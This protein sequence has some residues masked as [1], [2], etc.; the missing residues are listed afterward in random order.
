MLCHTIEALIY[1]MSSNRA[2]YLHICAT[3]LKSITGHAARVY[4]SILRWLMAHEHEYRNAVDGYPAFGTTSLEK[5]KECALYMFKE[6]AAPLVPRNKF[7]SRAQEL[8]ELD[9]FFGILETPKHIDRFMDQKGIECQCR[10]AIDSLI[11][12]ASQQMAHGAWAWD[13]YVYTVFADQLIHKCEGQP[14]KLADGSLNRASIRAYAND[15]AL[16]M[17]YVNTRLQTGQQIAIYLNIRDPTLTWAEVYTYTRQFEKELYAS[18]L[19]K[20]LEGQFDYYNQ[21]RTMPNV[22]Y[23]YVARRYRRIRV[24]QHHTKALVF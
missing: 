17:A 4:E 10:E 16:M 9:L 12:V 3:E 15:A 20:P 8:R 6:L 24:A 1:K 7:N 11:Q 2:N 5:A 22:A 14:E 21:V 13:K 23:E 18:A 19:S